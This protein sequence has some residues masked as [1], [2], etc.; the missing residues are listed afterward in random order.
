MFY[1]VKQ[2]IIPCSLEIQ[3]FPLIVVQLCVAVLRV[4][5]TKAAIL[6]IIN[7]GMSASPHLTKW[8]TA[9]TSMELAVFCPR[10]IPFHIS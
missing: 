4:S 7:V 8:P 3:Y 2:E 6:T 10:L 5:E 9:Y 1:L